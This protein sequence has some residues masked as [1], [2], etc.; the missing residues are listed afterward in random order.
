MNYPKISIVTPSFNQGQYL[1]QTILSILDQKYP[2]LEYII[3]DGGSTDN[4]VEI[5]K[6]YEKH[7]SYWISEKD[8]GQSDAINKGLKKISGDLFNWLNSDDYLEEASLFKLAQ[9]F[10]DN[11]T[12]KLFVFGLSYFDG[13]KKTLRKWKIFPSDGILFYCD[14]TIAQPSM[15]YSGDAVKKM[16]ELNGMLH[17]AMDY[18]WLIKFLFVFG[19]KSIFQSDFPFSVFRLHA[20]AKTSQGEENFVN[21]IA[22]ILFS[23]AKSAGLEKYSMLLQKG[24]RIYPDYTCDIS[25]NYIVPVTVERMLVY[26]LLQHS[27]RIYNEKQYLFAKEVFST[28]TF[29]SFQL[30]QNEIQWLEELRINAGSSSWLLFRAKRKLNHILNK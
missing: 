3:I 13:N 7:L 9:A 24:Y 30:S 2:N 16:G 23:L 10:T 11:P 8:K 4:S 17:Y 26:F 21:D 1:E 18:E 20:D 22:N 19:D 14:P 25:K 29:S 28:V 15:F 12:S 5:I 6:K 27:H